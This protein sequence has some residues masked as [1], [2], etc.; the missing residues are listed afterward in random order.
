MA[1]VLLVPRADDSAEDLQ[2]AA[3]RLAAL[4][5]R[6]PITVRTA[7]GDLASIVDVLAGA[8]CS[9]AVVS[10]DLTAADAAL[11]RL[12]D[13]PTLTVGALV[14]DGGSG[15]PVATAGATVLTAGTPLHPIEDADAD[16]L[17]AL[18]VDAG[19]VGAAADALRVADRPDWA[20]IDVPDLALAA[21]TRSPALPPVTAVRAEPFPAGRGT[22]VDIRASPDLAA[23]TAARSGDGW[24]STFVLRRLSARITPWAVRRGIGANAVTAVS[25]VLGLAGAGA[26]ALGAYPWLVAGALLLQVS[27]VLDCVDGEIARATRTRSAF[28]GWLDAATD[29]VK[30][31]AALAGLALAGHGLWALALAGMVVQTVRHLQDFA[32]DKGVL[33]R[34]RAALRDVRPLEDTSTWRRPDGAGRGPE[35]LH[36]PAGMWLRR[37]IRMPIGERW[38]VLSLAAVA[39]SPA[40]GLI[41]Y[42]GTAV[43][44]EAWTVLGALRRTRGPVGRYGADLRAVLAAYR[45]DG[46]LGL[47]TGARSPGGAAGWMLPP[48]TAAIEGGALFGCALLAAPDWTSAAF[49][50]FAV[51]AWHRYDVV[52]RRVGVP[53]AV[54]LLG[55]GWPVRSAVVLVG[56]LAGM[57]PAVLVAGGCWLVLVYVPESLLAGARTRRLR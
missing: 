39:G 9:V 44:A 29:R 23:R 14:A 28:G 4:P 57:L 41:A 31:Y 55:G 12:L 27:L 26:F 10:S 46:V 37:V 8:P 53:M 2:R 43:L 34:W 56:A 33:A 52:Y 45:D 24:Y 1:L 7:G 32:F 47:A 48:V 54:G 13:D 17:G 11:L 25:A 51:S 50:W 30:E 35:P 19:V 5:A 22:A 15:H 40:S 16:Y 20:H 3:Q 18:F 42:L 36:G 38:L 6:D 21:L 49:G